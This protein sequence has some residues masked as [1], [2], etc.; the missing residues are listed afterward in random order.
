MSTG[1][2]GRV[3]AL[4]TELTSSLSDCDTLYALNRD[5][6]VSSR[7]GLIKFGTLLIEFGAFAARDVAR[8]RAVEC[9]SEMMEPVYDLR[10]ERSEVLIE[11]LVCAPD[12][13]TYEPQRT[14]WYRR[15]LHGLLGTGFLLFLVAVLAFGFIRGVL[16]IRHWFF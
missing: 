13:A 3:T 14:P 4:A 7:E 2:A 12:P 10:D 5:G 8:G 16:V 15:L 1:V 11:S 9:G 6:F